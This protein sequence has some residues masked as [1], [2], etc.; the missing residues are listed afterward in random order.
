MK[1][2]GFCLMALLALLLVQ[3]ASAQSR[4]GLTAGLNL[5]NISWDD[6]EEGLGA[7]LKTYTALGFSGV[8]DVGLSENVALHVEP[9]YLQKGSKVEADGEELGKFKLAYIEIPALLKIALG[10]STTRPY[11]MVGPTIGI[12]LSAKGEDTD[13]EEE[14]IKEIFK[15]VDFGL[16]FGAGVSFP[17]GNNSFFIEGRYLLGLSNIID[18]GDTEAKNR[19]IQVMAG[20]TFPLGGQ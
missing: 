19:G 8:L 6:F 1:K 4:L 13:G 18:S 15:D 5:A 14:D 9:M 12:L 17:T 16:G 11:V 3:P 10:A 2:L 7:D 20:V